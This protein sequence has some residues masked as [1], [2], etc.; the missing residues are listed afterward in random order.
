MSNFTLFFSSSLSHLYLTIL[1]SVWSARKVFWVF[2]ALFTNTLFQFQGHCRVLL[3]CTVLHLVEFEPALFLALRS[4]CFPFPRHG[5]FGTHVDGARCV[6]QDG[7]TPLAVALQQG[8]DQV[9]SLLLENDT[10]GK[11]RLPALH[12]AAR[13]DDTKAA[14]LLLQNDHNADV[15]SKVSREKP[16]GLMLSG[17]DHIPGRSPSVWIILLQ[18]H[19]TFFS[20]TWLTFHLPPLP[21][22]PPFPCCLN[23]G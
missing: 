13:K 2:G 3:T 6:L 5:R 11:V 18:L 19:R 17:A 23:Q 7:F 15:E 8:H 4:R 9:V 21:L 1:C 14:A 10:K 16:E 20:N 12:I 22:S